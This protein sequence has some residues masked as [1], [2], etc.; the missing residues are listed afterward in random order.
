MDKNKLALLCIDDS[1]NPVNLVSLTKG[2]VY[3][4]R[5]QTSDY[6]RICDDAGRMSSF[7]KRRFIELKKRAK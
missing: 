6:Y 1:N 4:G 3:F 2:K 7:F 5:E